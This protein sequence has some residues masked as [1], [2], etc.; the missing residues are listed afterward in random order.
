MANIKTVSFE[1]ITPAIAQRY[2]DQNKVNRKL[3]ESRVALFIN[4]ILNGLWQTTHQGIAF[5]IHG[6]ISDGQHRLHA[7]VR[8]NTTVEVMVTRGL[9]REE[10]LA[11]DTA[12]LVRTAADSAHYAGV[13][14]DA[15]AWPIVKILALGIANSNVTVPFDKHLGWLEYY[16]D[17][18]E[19]AVEARL[20]CQP[21]KQKFTAPMA[22]A[23]GRAYY[24]ENEKSLRDMLEI[25]KSG[26]K[27]SEA[28]AAAFVLREAWTLGR[29]GSRNMQY[30]KT[31]AAIRA[32][33]ERRRIKTL[34]SAETE[35]WQL[36]KL[37]PE[38]QYRTSQPHQAAPRRGL[39]A[40]LAFA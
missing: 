18:V 13:V 33:T 11:V 29:L 38:L 20:H 27:R 10:T 24:S 19:F 8:T 22:A 26:Q 6:N 2:L 35:I 39:P 28:D 32:F 34:Q 1:T 12:A 14:V 17:G 37:P 5:D 25:V 15:F 9:N 23:F 3:R 31:S 36:D 30:F 4:I 21:N 16:R 7:I 40:K